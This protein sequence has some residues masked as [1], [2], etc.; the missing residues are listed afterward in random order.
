MLIHNQLVIV[1]LHL[2]K[3]QHCD[4]YITVYIL[5]TLRASVVILVTG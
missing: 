1:E 5:A 4:Y 3:R 2:I